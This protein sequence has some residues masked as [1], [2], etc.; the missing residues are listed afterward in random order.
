VIQDSAA[1]VRR[2]ID[3]FIQRNRIPGIQYTVVDAD[4]IRFEH[5][6]G[7]ADLASSRLVSP[8]TTF[9]ASSSTKVIT[10]AA[11]LQLAERQ[12][13]E[14]DKPLSTYYSNHSYTEKVTIRHLLTQT[15]GM[16]NPL[17]LKWLHRADGHDRFNEER[18]LQQTLQHHSKLTSS[19][20]EKYGYS[21][22]SYWLLGKAVESA[23]GRS[24]SEYVR[25]QIFEPLEIPPSAASFQIENPVVHATGY[26]RSLSLQGLILYLLMDRRL[27][28]KTVKGYRSL[29]PVYMNGPAYGGLICTATAFG[30]FLQELL[31]PTPRL[32][33]AQT[34]ELMFKH[35]V[36]AAGN[37]TGMSLGWRIGHTQK[38]PY[39]GKP[40]GGPGFRSNVRLY[41]R[42]G[43]GV[44]WLANETGVSE[45]QMNSLS[46]AIDRHWFSSWR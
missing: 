2:D 29:L 33:S 44:A 41:P 7:Y 8:E 38:E 35:Q 46:D 32:F 11:V 3:Q 13:L 25:E 30:L 34:R 22:I 39:Y 5:Q 9:M 26:Q 20:G 40:G 4:G 21:N 27:L 24:F 43:L 23:S 37:E 16:P 31:R 15:A 42:L 12:K 18:A 45:T 6:S 14:L 28:G 17:P 19:P 1:V 36:T 10:A